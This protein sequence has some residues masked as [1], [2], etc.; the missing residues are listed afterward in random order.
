VR[1]GASPGTA[2]EEQEQLK[3]G[4]IAHR[5]VVAGV[6]EALSQ[7]ARIERMHGGEIAAEEDAAREREARGIADAAGRQ[8]AVS[9][10]VA[11]ALATA[12]PLLVEAGDGQ[13]IRDA[14]LVDEGLRATPAP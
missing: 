7:L 12:E 14:D 10:E 1:R 2:G 5:I 3:A 9:H 13:H 8:I 6:A 11:E 4:L